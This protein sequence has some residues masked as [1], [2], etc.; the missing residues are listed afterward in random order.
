MKSIVFYLGYANLSKQGYG[1]EGAL[2]YLSN[3]LKQWFKI[4]ILSFYDIENHVLDSMKGITFLKPQEYINNTYDILII[5]RYIN[6]YLYFPVLAP[7]VYVWLQDVSLHSCGNG[8][9]FNENGRYLM[10]NVLCDGF[11]VQTNW[12]KNIV[13]KLY[14]NSPPIHIIG[15]GIDINKFSYNSVKT[16]WRFIWS[17]SPIR[18]LTYMLKIFP[19]I[20]EKYPESTL[21]I[22]RDIEEFTQEQ[23]DIINKHSYIHYEGAKSN[24]DI[25]KEFEK[26]QFWLYPTN[27]CE[28]YCI[29][30]L[31]AQASGCF[32]ICTNLASL[33]EVVADRGVLL[34]SEYGSDEYLNDIFNAIE[35]RNSFNVQKVYEWTKEQ[36]WANRALMWK[37]LL[38]KD[39]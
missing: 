20:K 12:H 13:E 30:A 34:N 37:N 21:Y 33:G 38:E 25:I 4:Y 22:F 9:L 18:G 10:E 29:S 35:N 19:L 23:L 5:Y 31:E 14:P 16:P 32:C 2:I 27:F 7:I 24:S 26:S 11:I 28:T 6:Y 39:N 36:D 8:D 17:S 3:Y 15:N 1:S